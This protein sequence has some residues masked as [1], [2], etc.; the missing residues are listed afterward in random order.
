MVTRECKNVDARDYII[1]QPQAVGCRLLL[2]MNWL[3][4]LGFDDFPSWG[5]ASPGQLKKQ[6]CLGEKSAIG[7]FDDC[8]FQEG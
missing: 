8:L 5:K 7:R 4:Y 2:Q 6:V 3:G 1:L